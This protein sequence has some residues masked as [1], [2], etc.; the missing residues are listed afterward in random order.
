MQIAI[1]LVLNTSFLVSISIIFN[2]Y[3]QKIQQQKIVYKFIG[4]IILGLAGVIL[5]TISLKLPNGVIFDTRSILISISGLF[6]GFLPT[7]IAH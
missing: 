4:G 2:L 5:L 6:Y 7:S 3:F 1:N